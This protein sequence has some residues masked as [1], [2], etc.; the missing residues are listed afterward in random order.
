[1]LVSYYLFKYC[2]Y[3][4]WIDMGQYFSTGIRACDTFTK[5]LNDNLSI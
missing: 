2:S 1:M 5:Q 4:L 3:G